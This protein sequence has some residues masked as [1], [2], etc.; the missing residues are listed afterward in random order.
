MQGFLLELLNFSCGG[1]AYSAVTG[2][3]SV[4]LLH[5]KASL[6]FFYSIRSE[7]GRNPGMSDVPVGFRNRKVKVRQPE[8]DR[9]LVLCSTFCTASEYNR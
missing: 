7:G 4:D 3:E 6:L 2:L 1:T 8:P 9:R 5:L